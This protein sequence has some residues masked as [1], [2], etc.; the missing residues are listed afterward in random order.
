MT[1]KDREDLAAF[2]LRSRAEGP[3]G[4]RVLAA[5]EAVPRR[6]FVPAGIADAFAD[7]SV[8]IECGETM[9][10]V[11]KVVRLLTALRVQ[12]D[13]RILEVGTGSGYVTALLAKLGA[14]IVSLDRY[15]VLLK[16]AGERLKAC[17]LGNV[18]LLLE[19][20]RLGHADAGP[21][22]RILVHAAF[23]SVPKV[24]LDQIGSQGLMICAVGPGNAPQMLLRQ[25]KI[26]SRFEVEELYPVRYQSLAFGTA[27]VL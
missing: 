3:A 27:A 10:S 13:S 15:R 12:P 23:E 24:F 20:G 22:D 2:L 18:S 21:Y 7:Q 9:P 25:Q 1:E 4:A 5:V 17:G 6:L 26:G 16:S 8:P 14:R 19:D 11:R